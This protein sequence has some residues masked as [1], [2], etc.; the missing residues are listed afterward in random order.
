VVAVAGGAIALVPSPATAIVI[1]AIVFGAG[2]AS[3]LSRNQAWDV[4]AQICVVIGALM[5]AGGVIALGR[6]S[7]SAMLMV[8]VGLCVASIIARSSLLMAASILALGASLG[9]RTGYWHATYALAIYEPLLTIV[10]FSLV[11]LG[12]YQVSK[13]LTADYERLAIAAARTSVFMVNFGFWIGSLWGDRLLLLRTLLQSDLGAA[14]SYTRVIVPLVFTVG[15]A[16]ALLAVGLWAVRANKRWTVNVVAVFAGIHFY[17]QWFE[18]LGAN[19][20]SVLIGGI[21]VLVF[22]LGL[23]KFN[24]RLAAAVS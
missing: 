15:W 4:L 10:L 1:G 9:A 13:R 2:L 12:A 21:L 17:T 23:W 5:M 19:P 6:G 14:N 24:Q 3:I 7:L 20:L 11:A 16:L 22:A 18:I 8:A